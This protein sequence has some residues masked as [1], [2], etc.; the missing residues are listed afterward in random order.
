MNFQFSRKPDST[1][2]AP[3]YSGFVPF[4]EHTICSRG[5]RAPSKC[6]VPRVQDAEIERGRRW[7]LPSRNSRAGWEDRHNTAVTTQGD[8]AGLLPTTMILLLSL[9]LCYF[10]HL[11]PRKPSIFSCSFGTQLISHMSLN[12]FLTTWASSSLIS[13]GTSNSAHMK[14]PCTDCY[15][16]ESWDLLKTL[17]M[18]LYRKESEI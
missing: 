13:Y 16:L 5:F 12:M 1:Y 8:T 9:S 14:L 7:P 4:S 18:V 3:L 17:Q 10:S 11:F 15:T 2:P 6:L